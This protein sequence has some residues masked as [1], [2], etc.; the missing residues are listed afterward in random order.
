MTTTSTPD[1]DLTTPAQPT[2]CSVAGRPVP[3]ELRPRLVARLHARV[4]EAVGRG[5]DRG[6]V[7]GWVLVTVMSA[8]V[9]LAL[10]AAA[11]TMLPQI[12]REAVTSVR[13]G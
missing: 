2:T 9:V 4:H 11:E 8:A 1:S 10:W 12:F 6:D 5:S 13:G 7:P 3:K